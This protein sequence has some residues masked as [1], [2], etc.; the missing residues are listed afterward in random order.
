MATNILYRFSITPTTPGSTSAKGSPLTYDELDGNFKSIVTA[1]DAHV[2]SNGASHGVVAAGGNS[3]FMSGADKS[4]LDGIASNATANTGTVTTVS[5]ATANGFGGTVATAGTTPVITLSTNLTGLLKGS[6]S[7]LAAAVAG[8]DYVAPG[9]A[10]GTPTSGNLANCTFPTL[11]QNTTGTAAG[12]SSAL[13]IATGGT[14]GTTGATAY[15]ALDRS[16]TV[17]VNSTGTTFVAGSTYMVSTNGAAYS[18]TMPTA[19]TTAQG[20]EIRVSNM[21]AYWATYNFTINCPANVFFTIYGA[22]SNTTDTALVCNVN[23][24]GFTLR[25]AY[26]DGTNAYWAII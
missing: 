16:A 14:G 22:G 9:G 2:G 5:V 3:G 13:G 15:K 8:T 23:V 20:D 7:A 4:K 6:S 18:A 10:L 24:G 21:L 12:L 26:H 11:N 19:A 25:C 17:Y 1:L